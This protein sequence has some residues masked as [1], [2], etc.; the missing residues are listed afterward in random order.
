MVKILSVILLVLLLIVGRLKGLKNF[1]CFYLNYFLLVGY[2]FMMG[3]GLNAIIISLLTCVLS[4]VSTLFIVNGYNV[5]TR[6]SF[7]SVLII[8][9]VMFFMIF[10]IG[11]LANIQGFSKEYAETI[12]I[13][14]MDINYNM[15]D[16]IVGIVIVCTIGTVTDTALSV[17]TALNEVHANNP[18]IPQKEL[19][20]SGMNVGRDILSTTINTLLFAFLGGLTAFFLWH[21]AD[22]METVLNGKAF[23]QELFELLSCLIAS[24]LVIPV[25]SHI[26]SKSLLKEGAYKE[27]GKNK[28]R[29]DAEKPRTGT[30]E[31]DDWA[32]TE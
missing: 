25:T 3:L 7:K 10:I 1:I 8:L 9:G 15:T 31:R 12:G 19:F 23:I 14:S 21:Q 13:Y 24:V 4:A 6:S 5:K 2:I 11:R 20:R 17:S 26:A 32:D 29:N 27:T 28:K 30:S 18:D 22:P 16:V